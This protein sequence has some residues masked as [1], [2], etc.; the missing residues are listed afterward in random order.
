MTFYHT[1]KWNNK[2]AIGLDLEPEQGRGPKLKLEPK[3]A[4]KLLLEPEPEMEQELERKP[5]SEQKHHF[6]TPCYDGS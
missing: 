4:P 5:N 2:W 3:P 6:K 1:S